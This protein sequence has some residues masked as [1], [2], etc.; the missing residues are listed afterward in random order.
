MRPDE[1]DP[2]YVWDM[3][4]HAR[5]AVAISAGR[6]LADLSNDRLFA[7]AI[8]RLIEIIGEAANNLSEGFRSQQPGIPWAQIRGQRNVI[9]HGYREID[10]SRIWQTLS[11]SL[12]NLIRELGS[13]M[14]LPPEEP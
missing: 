3:V 5:E 11:E 6:T 4:Y 8:E 13:L 10:Y 14:A 1:R 2:G 12:P 7:L 9:A